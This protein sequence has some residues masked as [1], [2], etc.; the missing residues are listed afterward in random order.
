MSKIKLEDLVSKLKTAGILSPPS[1][2]SPPNFALSHSNISDRIK[3]SDL[4]ID[5]MTQRKIDKSRGKK[6]NKIA[7][8]FDSYKFGMPLVTQDIDGTYFVVDGQGRSI[9]AVLVALDE[10]PCQILLKPNVTAS[11]SEFRGEIYITQNDNVETLSGWQLHDVAQNLPNPHSKSAKHQVYRARDIKNL[12]TKLNNNSNGWTFGYH[13]DANSSRTKYTVDL[14][15]SY[16]YVVNGIIRPTHNIEC[17]LGA[18]D[19]TAKSLEAAL[20]VFAEYLPEQVVVGQ[21]LDVFTYY[22]KQTTCELRNNRNLRDVTNAEIN[23]AAKRLCYIL[24]YHNCL[25]KVSDPYHILKHQELKE[26]LGTTNKANNE[27]AIIGD[28]KLKELWAT[29]LKS[30]QF[31][32]EQYN[33][34]TTKFTIV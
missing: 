33:R 11:G 4:Y 32:T 6:I 30:K 2:F 23:D 29:I 28:I 8:D 1:R 3:T 7:G 19:R 13:I 25:K 9:A 5:P 20:N 12:L 27:V 10:I 17:G 22:I 31:S 15:K 34:F 18:G 14:T 24:H 26:L 21:N 16:E